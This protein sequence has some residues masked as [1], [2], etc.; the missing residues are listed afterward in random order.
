MIEVVKS[1]KE[2]E[3]LTGIRLMS[4]ELE[5]IGVLYNDGP[6]S[7]Q[8]LMG[9]VRASPSGFHLIK[10]CMQDTGLIVGCRSEQDARVKLL[11]LSPELRANLRTIY[12]DRPAPAPDS[13]R[14]VGGSVRSERAMSA[15]SA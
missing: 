15:L 3:G 14:N 9:K 6:I 2:I 7:V 10:K 13:S 8:A 12:Q 4:T 5:I 1:L 11:D